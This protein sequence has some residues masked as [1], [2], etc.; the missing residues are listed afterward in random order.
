MD[1]LLSDVQ[2]FN[3]EFAHCPGLRL[4]PRYPSGAKLVK[5]LII[6]HNELIALGPCRDLFLF[7]GPGAVS[8]LWARKSEGLMACASAEARDARMMFDYY[9]R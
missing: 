2:R 6:C 7:V 8:Q 3:S 9:Y 4:S 1:V 5:I